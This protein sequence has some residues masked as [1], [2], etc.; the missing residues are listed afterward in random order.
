MS[1][2]IVLVAFNGELMCFAHVLL[3]ALDMHQKGYDI[4][5]VIEG[6]ACGLIEQLNDP[7]K[8][9]GATYIEFREKGLI[10]C[11]CQACSAKMGT[12]TSA[13][14]QNL[15]LR[16]ELKG[17]PALSNYIDDGYQIITF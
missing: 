12:L 2:R 4:K 17:H 11:V 5:V 9:F 10:D 3:N 1:K 8:P 7:A 13:Q 6:A 14:E 16:N 15:P